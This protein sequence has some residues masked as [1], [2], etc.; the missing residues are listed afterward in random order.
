MCSWAGWATEDQGWVPRNYFATD[1]L[2][3]LFDE[4]ND[5]F[6]DI[7]AQTAVDVDDLVYE[8]DLKKVRAVAGK[9][10]RSSSGSSYQSSGGT[11]PKL[12][13]KRGTARRK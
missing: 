3:R 12:N 1:A 7:P 10:K 8:D 6:R 13:K 11:A 4:H 9:D 5:P 2:L